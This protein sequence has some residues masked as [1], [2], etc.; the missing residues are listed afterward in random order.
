MLLC[1]LYRFIGVISQIVQ[2]AL[3]CKKTLHSCHLLQ[4]CFIS[5][6]RSLSVCLSVWRQLRRLF[7]AEF[8]TECDIMLLSS[9]SGISSFPYGQP[10][11]CLRLS[12][13]LFFPS[14]SPSALFQAGNETAHSLHV[15][16]EFGAC[17]HSRNYLIAPGILQFKRNIK[18]YFYILE[19]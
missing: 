6:I 14:I 12:H 1:K 17:D 18:R 9:N 11:S 3:K 10:S 7:Q 2:H 4:P 19:L 5:S 13:R 16:V 15:A 8:S